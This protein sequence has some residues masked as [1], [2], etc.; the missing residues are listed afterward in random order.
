MH[1]SS[2]TALRLGILITGLIMSTA[3]NE[4]VAHGQGQVD[5][6][7]NKA[8]NAVA[9]ITEAQRTYHK[10]NGSFQANI[11]SLQE[12]FAITLPSS[13]N[14]AARTTTYSAYNYVIPTQPANTGSLKAF[15]G[16]TF[17]TPGEKP[18]MITI[19]CQNSQPGQI[20]PADPILVLGIA[21]ANPTGRI[22]QCGDFSTQVSASVVNE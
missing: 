12:D 4:T 14:Y 10:K 19:I 21:I 5:I 3:L 6:D 22:V 13:F 17:F 16:A 9:K 20:R 1:K 7:Q 18:K 15:V 11:A 8:L 2:T